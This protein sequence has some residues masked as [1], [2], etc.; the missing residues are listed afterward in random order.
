MLMY[1]KLH[2]ILKSVFYNDAQHGQV[3]VINVQIPEYTDT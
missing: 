2:D 1:E 3:E